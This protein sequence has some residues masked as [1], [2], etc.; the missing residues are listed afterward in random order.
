M[1]KKGLALIFSMCIAVIL[2][3]FIFRAVNA[4]SQKVV[5]VDSNPKASSADAKLPESLK[6]SPE[7]RKQNAEAIAESQGAADDENFESFDILEKEWLTNVQEIIGP[8]LYGQYLEMRNQNE[9][10]KMQAYKEYHDYLRQKYGDKF[11]YN[12]SEDQST[13]EKEINQRYLKELLKLIGPEKFKIYTNSKDKFN[14]VMRK[15]N[16]ESIQIEF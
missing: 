5:V 6:I 1:N 4:P 12:I 14:E 11:T 9:K 15:K 3:W 7:S 8:D 16:K 2:F 13:R 10:E